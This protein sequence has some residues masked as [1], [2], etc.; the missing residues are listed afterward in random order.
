MPYFFLYYH[1]VLS[2]RVLMIE[3]MSKKWEKYPIEKI[4]TQ[5][6]K[7]LI[8]VNKRATNIKSR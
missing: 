4:Y 7:Y 1:T 8:G 6:Y 2:Y 3:L 5:L